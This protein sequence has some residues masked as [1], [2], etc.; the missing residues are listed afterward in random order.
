[1]Q[2]DAMIQK[3]LFDSRPDLQQRIK[4]NRLLRLYSVSVV[5]LNPGNT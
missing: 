1:M 4:R 5:P 2:H 3:H